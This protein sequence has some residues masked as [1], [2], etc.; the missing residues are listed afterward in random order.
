MLADQNP[1]I[2]IFCDASE[3]MLKDATGTPIQGVRII[4]NKIVNARINAIGLQYVQD[5]EIIGNT[6]ENPMAAGLQTA[7][8][9]CCNYDTASAIYLNTVRDTKITDNRIE[10]QDPKLVP[11]VRIS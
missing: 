2:H 9:G 4:N 5:A 8:G 1:A 7:W 10:L 11:E 6:L 3:A